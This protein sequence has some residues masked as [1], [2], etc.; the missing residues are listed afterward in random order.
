MNTENQSDL[1]TESNN[2]T[3]NESTPSAFDQTKLADIVSKTFLGG[4]E[5]VE[6]SD[7][8]KQAEA[9]GNAIKIS[10]TAEKEA[11]QMRGQGIA[12]FRQEV[13]KGMSEAIKEMEF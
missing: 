7:S 6:N 3:T 13:A 4:E 5:A 9:D 12:L 8:E 1:G 2:P 10:A 11:A